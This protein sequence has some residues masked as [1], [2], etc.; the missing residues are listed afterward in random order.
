MKPE[1]TLE[2]IGLDSLGT[3]EIL[4]AVEDEFGIELDTEENPKTV[5]ELV[6]ALRAQMPLA[7][8]SYEGTLAGIPVPQIKVAEL[9]NDANLYGAVQEA[10]RLV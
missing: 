6:D 1:S 2:E 5:G 10:M 9:G 4:V 7:L 3:V 8:A